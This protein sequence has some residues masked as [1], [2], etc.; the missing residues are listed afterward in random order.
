MGQDRNLKETSRELLRKIPSVDELLIDKRISS[1]LDD[2]SRKIVVDSIREVLEQKRKSILKL[3]DCTQVDISEENIVELVREEVRQRK[4]YSLKRVINATGVVVHTNLGRSLLCEP[5]LSHLVEVSRSYSNLEFDLDR[6]VRGS[7]YVHVEDL[8]CELTGAESAM[9]VNNNAGAVLL[10][11]NTLAKDKEVIVSRG[12]LVEIGGAFRIPDVMKRSGAML[13]EIGTTNRT[14]LRDYQE[15]I[16][17]NTALIMKVHTSNFQV[18]GFFSEVPLKD[19]VAL[20]RKHNIPVIEDLGSGNLVDLS[21]YGLMK[22]PPVQE[23]VSAGADAVMF[24]G[25]KMLGGPQ[26][27]I[28]VGRKELLERIKRNPINRALRIDKLT[29]AALEATLRFYRDEE[30]AV[31][32]IPT[33]KMLTMPVE[34]IKKKA[35]RLHRN[36]GQLFQGRWRCLTTSESAY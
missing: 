21:K 4:E 36:N 30:E 31:N 10:T 18:V 13:V 7:R 35:K 28:I 33:L 29:L 14:H 2:T 5:A 32:N 16:T 19:L 15:A 27:G 12:Q 20:G 11:L 23:V 34:T 3:K 1:L 22:E 24:S 25:D 17:D 6:G 8:L 9:V 26:A